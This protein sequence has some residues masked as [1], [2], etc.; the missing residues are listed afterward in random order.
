MQLL[1][2]T[3]VIHEGHFPFSVKQIEG[4]IQNFLV[5]FEMFFFAL[6]FQWAFSA[7]AYNPAG[8]GKEK[9]VEEKLRLKKKQEEQDLLDAAKAKSDEF[10]E[11]KPKNKSK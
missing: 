1:A 6:A 10:R 5:C 11:F 9:S 8:E 2:L 4:A 3:G 7:E